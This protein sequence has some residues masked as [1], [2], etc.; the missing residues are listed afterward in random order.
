MELGNH[1]TISK[2]ALIH[3]FS[4]EKGRE[5]K[6]KNVFQNAFNQVDEINEGIISLP[7][8]NIEEDAPRDSDETQQQVYKNASVRSNASFKKKLLHNK[9]QGYGPGINGS[10][11]SNQP[12]GQAHSAYNIQKSSQ[13]IFNTGDS[14]REGVIDI[15]NT[16]AL[17]QKLQS[18]GTAYEGGGDK[19]SKASHK[20]K[21][22][23]RSEF[24]M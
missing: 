21:S 16:Y 5:R 2:C 20:S 9:V 11:S 15:H 10:D 14:V 22:L 24:L 3:Q 1:I 7:I 13:C 19:S 4:G 12:L 8:S 23:G 17:I 6:I 18:E